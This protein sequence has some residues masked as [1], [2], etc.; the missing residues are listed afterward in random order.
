MDHLDE[1]EENIISGK[2]EENQKD[3]I[4]SKS[5]VDLM[6]ARLEKSA[7]DKQVRTKLRIVSCSL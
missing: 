7:I 4:Y 6:L 3:F 2:F 5:F 1:I